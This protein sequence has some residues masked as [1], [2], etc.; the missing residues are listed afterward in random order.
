MNIDNPFDKKLAANERMPESFRS[1]LVDSV[2]TLDFCWAGVRAVFGDTA[3]PEHAI[4][5]LP[6]VMARQDAERQRLRDDAAGR[7]AGAR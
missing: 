6:I 1:A 5:L 3:T 4:A 7:T 2:D